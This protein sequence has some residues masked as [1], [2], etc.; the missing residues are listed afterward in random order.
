MSDKYVHHARIHFDLSAAAAAAWERGVRWGLV[1]GSSWV[2]LYGREPTKAR[3][4]FEQR[5]Q[6]HWFRSS[7]AR[8]CWRRESGNPPPD[9]CVF[10]SVRE[11]D[12]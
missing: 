3:E 4:I 2:G 5:R 10:P 6:A 7:R 12:P 1:G 9:T 11:A 8:S